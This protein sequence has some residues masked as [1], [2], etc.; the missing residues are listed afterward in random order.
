M[1]EV[2]RILP[3][4]SSCLIHSEQSIQS[5]RLLDVDRRLG[6]RG[7]RGGHQLDRH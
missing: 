1:S 7:H 3:L 6:G 5:R 4:I 2:P